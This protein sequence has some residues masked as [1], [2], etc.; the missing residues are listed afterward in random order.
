[1]GTLTISVSRSLGT[2]QEDANLLTQRG[3]LP[4]EDSRFAVNLEF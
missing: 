4:I 3:R 1:M 2:Q